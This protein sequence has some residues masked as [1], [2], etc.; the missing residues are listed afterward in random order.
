[1]I[2]G[3]TIKAS[4]ASV[5]GARGSGGAGRGGGGAWGA[6]SPTAGVLCGRAA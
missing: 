4:I 3:V 1:M 5:N 2:P 6:V